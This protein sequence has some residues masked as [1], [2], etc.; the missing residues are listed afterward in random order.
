VNGVREAVWLGCRDKTCCYAALVVPTGYDAWRIARALDAPPWSFLMYFKSPAP[1]RDAFALDRSGRRFRLALA[2]S[3]MLRREEQP[4][5]TFLIRT[6]TGEHRC[7]LGDLRPTGCRVFPLELTEGLVRVQAGH[8]CT[9]RSWSLAD[10]DTAA[11]RQLLEARVRESEAYC[12]VVRAWNA[13][14]HGGDPGI[15]FSFVQYCEYLLATY[16]R[17][18]A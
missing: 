17:M 4:G 7:G 3:Q 18:A 13:S 8:G 9:C 10:V 14:V 11:E 16:D 15:D 2:K 6:R 5:C 12:D 1:R